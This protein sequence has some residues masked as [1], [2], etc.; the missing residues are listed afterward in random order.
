MKSYFE[1]I[2]EHHYPWYLLAI[3][4]ILTLPS[5]GLAP[6]FDY[7]ETIYAQTAVDM[8]RLGEW[9]VPTAN[10]QQF[11]EKPPFTYYMMDVCFQ[12]L[13]QN[14]FAARLPSA[15]FTLMTAFLL[16]R[17]GRDV[18]SA[19]FGIT[20]ALVFLS[21][22]E[23]AVL[24]HA[25]ILDAILNFF[26]VSCLLNYVRWIQTGEKKYAFWCA[27]MMGVGV[28]IKGPVGMVVPVLIIL[29]DRILAGDLKRT[30]AS[31]P[32]LPALLLFIFTASPWYAMIFFEHGAGF[33]YE[34]IMVQNIGRALHPMQGHGGGWHYYLV[35][36][37]ISV[38]PWLAW[39]P[40]VF[41]SW[42]RT[43]QETLPH[44]IRLSLLWLLIVLLLFTFAQ[45][46]LPHY[47]SCVYPA[48]A[49]AIV[50]AWW[51]A[52]YP[53]SSTQMIQRF[54]AIILLPIALVL[55][56]FQ[57][58]YPMIKEHVHHPRAV[59]VLNQG[60]EPNMGITI[61]GILL[62]A[63]CVW[64]WFNQ[65]PLSLLK[66]FMVAGFVLQSALLI[67]L[68]TFAGKLAQAPQSHI[69]QRL[70]QLPASMP[71]YSFNLNFPSM[72]FRSQRNYHIISD[73]Q[74]QKLLEDGGDYAIIMRSE[75]QVLLP[76]LQALTPAID[77]GGFVLYIH[78][79]DGGKK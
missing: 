14:A 66:K 77:Q 50:A 3:W 63:V 24:A 16:F 49:L 60:I 71:I 2:P 18:V 17:F 44:L 62:L 57:S 72:S 52:P 22:L 32:W 15:L 34:F 11:F 29:A 78:K 65:H 37:S 73:A 47:I 40:Y 21:M 46:K 54:S 42:Q 61:A 28:S 67:P 70:Q 45:T 51:Q 4:A 69:A 25:A 6:L 55:M 48:V 53:I 79:G 68:G 19:R 13:G 58:L 30:L 64:L 36:F 38:L 5:L 26:I 76:K 20:T 74:A 7:D 59:A 23:V 39:M 31:I 56:G 10:G 41:K 1:T 43:S 12:L 75:S 33:L 9:I 35:V 8:M 27:A